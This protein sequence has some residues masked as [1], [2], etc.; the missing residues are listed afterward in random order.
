MREERKGRLMRYASGGILAAYERQVHIHFA[1]HGMIGLLA[2]QAGKHYMYA[3]NK[4][5]TLGSN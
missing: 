3:K 5:V 1:T 2:D 4:T